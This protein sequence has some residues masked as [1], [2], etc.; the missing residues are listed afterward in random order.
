MILLVDT[1]AGRVASVRGRSDVAITD[2][3]TPEGIGAR[4]VPAD[5]LKKG[6]ASP[7][8]SGHLTNQFW[9]V[10]PHVI[11]KPRKNR[12]GAL[13]TEPHGIGEGLA[14]AIS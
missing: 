14:K 10:R 1:L 8:S 6:R 2:K 9:I 3:A 5:A 13:D 4:A 11:G 7:W 12:V